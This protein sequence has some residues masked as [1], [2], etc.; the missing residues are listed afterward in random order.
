MQLVWQINSQNNKP[1][2][3]YPYSHSKIGCYQQCPFKFKC[4]YIDKIKVKENLYHLNKGNY[5]HH[6]LEYFGQPNPPEKTFDLTQEEREEIDK[7]IENFTSTLR[8]KELISYPNSKNEIAIALDHEYT[9]IKY[10]YKKNYNITK[11]W[12]KIDRIHLY[13]NGIIHL[14]DWKSGKKRNYYKQLEEYALWS[15]IKFPNF[16]TIKCSYEFVEHNDYLEKIY[17][18]GDFERIKT[19]LE[20]EMNSI[21]KDTLFMKHKTGLCNFCEYGP[22]NAHICEGIK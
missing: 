14:I 3:Q 19:R 7:I 10:D 4:K 22:T 13:N 8:F 2:N 21:E 5:I 6:K 20:S 17:T 9:S 18:P 11:Y 15:M 12:G 1:N 16:H